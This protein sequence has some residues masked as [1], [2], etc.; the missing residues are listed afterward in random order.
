MREFT[1]KNFEEQLTKQV[2]HMDQGV[3]YNPEFRA[4]RRMHDYPSRK[5][6][7]A[8]AIYKGELEPT[9]YA[10]DI[11]FS[12]ILSG[13]GERWQNFGENNL[14][15]TLVSMLCREML[16]EK[17]VGHKYVNALMELLNKYDG[18][19][20]DAAGTAPVWREAMPLSRNSTV[21]LCLDDATAAYA[22]ASAPAFGRLM[23]DAGLEFGNTIEP[24]FAGY[25]YFAYGLIDGGIAHLQKWA[26]AIRG[27]GFDTVMTLSGQTEMIFKK[28][29][30]A[31]GIGH[32]L[33][34][35]NALDFLSPIKLPEPGYVYA[36]SFYT[37]MLRREA[38]FNALVPNT[39]ERV[40][41]SSVEFN[42]V[43][44][45]DNRVNT[46]TIWQPPVCAEF[47][48]PGLDGALQKAICEDA[49]MQILSANPSLVAVF[50]PYAYHALT[51]RGFD[52]KVTY[53]AELI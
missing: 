37:R 12:S 13:Q 52:K 38:L 11:V 42:P 8:R 18:H 2:L 46:V 5:L 45:A 30:P 49:A 39:A 17:G 34:V 7:I 15:Y 28:L 43:L 53:F 51:V 25:E 16:L 26:E 33:K 40:A 50:D 27:A 47:A 48:A 3:C 32:S 20:A 21:Y 35:F 24:V 6:Q 22:T 29:M 36:G 44:E 19:V 14:D 23:R 4:T 41:A 31:V 1:L 9:E 10:A